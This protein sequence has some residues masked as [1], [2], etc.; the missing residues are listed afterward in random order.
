[1][2]SPLKR[3]RLVSPPSHS[4]PGTEI[5]PRLGNISNWTPATGS[6]NAK[7]WDGVEVVDLSAERGKAF[8]LLVVVRSLSLS[9]G[10]EGK[11]DRAH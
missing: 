10:K 4:N 3:V 5:T 9:V 1:M 11:A 8:E 2:E 6:E 7:E